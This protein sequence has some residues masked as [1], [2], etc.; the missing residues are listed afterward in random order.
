MPDTRKPCCGDEAN[1]E[2]VHSVDVVLNG[3]V[4]QVDGS[5]VTARLPGTETLRRC[6]VCG[7][8]HFELTADPGHYALRGQPA[9]GK[10]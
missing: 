5:S 10:D 8:R 3:V 4:Q 6:R 2:F 1:L 9:G 7:C